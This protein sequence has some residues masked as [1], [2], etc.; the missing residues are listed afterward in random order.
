[1]PQSAVGATEAGVDMSCPTQ[2]GLDDP[3]PELG[4]RPGPPSQDDIGE[5]L[6][7]DSGVLGREGVAREKGKLKRVRTLHKRCV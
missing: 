2:D 6:Q 7:P 3:G 5:F 1:V 4:L